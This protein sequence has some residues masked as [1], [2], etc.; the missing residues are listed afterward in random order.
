MKSLLISIAL[1]SPVFAD[2]WK[3]VDGKTIIGDYVGLQ[4]NSVTLLVSGKKFIVPLEKL[5]PTSRGYAI[6]LNEG[7]KTWAK[8]N[9]ELPIVT[10]DLL[11]DMLRLAPEA[12]EGKH[13]ILSGFVAKVENPPGVSSLTPAKER[14]QKVG[15]VFAGGTKFVADFVGVADG[16]RAFVKIENGAAVLY[17]A[18]TTAYKEFSPRERLAEPG[19]KMCARVRVVAGKIVEQGMPTR[20]EVVAANAEFVKATGSSSD[21]ITSYLLKMN[22]LEYLKKA[23]SST[24][25]GT[26]ISS[27]GTVTH[28][29]MDYTDAELDRMRKEIEILQTSL[30]PTTKS[31]GDDK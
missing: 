18:L 31:S 21:A 7:F 15:I 6:F 26:A 10:E 30:Q 13:Y 3:S 22:R 20:D 16:V 23:V 8:A 24:A 11:F 17:K 4:G 28:I 29:S 25:Q 19:M 1:A 9:A 5:A 12:V 27:N 2:E 14:G